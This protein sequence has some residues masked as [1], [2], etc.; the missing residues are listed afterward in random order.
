[1]ASDRPAS[2]WKYYQT[3]PATHGMT[4]YVLR[5]IT[6]FFAFHISHYKLRRKKEAIENFMNLP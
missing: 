4:A 6:K 1:V 3:F 2:S 5:I